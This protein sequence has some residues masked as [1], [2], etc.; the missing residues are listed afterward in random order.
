MTSIPETMRAVL[1]TGHGGID[2]LQYI[3][4]YPVPI[5]KDGEVLV[6]VGASSVNNT[7]IN[8]RTAWYADTVTGGVTV[9][10]GERGFDEVGGASSGWSGSAFTFP[11]I[12]GADICGEIVAVGE[13]V[14]Q[15]RIGARIL[16]DVWIRDPGSPLDRSKIGCIGSECDGGFA[17][18][19]AIP[20]ICAHT[21]QSD[22][23]D[24]ELA[25]FPCA[26]TTAENLV[27]RTRVGTGDTVLITGASGGVGSAAIQLCN[28]RGATVIGMAGTA[29]HTMLKPI[30]VDALLPREVDDLEASLISYVD[31]GQ[32]D[33]VIDTVGGNQFGMLIHQLRP[34]GRYA[35]CGAI[36]GPIVT[37]DVRDLI[38]QDLEFFGGTVPLPHVFEDLVG[39]IERNEITPIVAEVYDLQQLPAAQKEFLRKRVVGKII[40]SVSR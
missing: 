8:T 36:A 37:F 9:S 6:R 5:P 35:S 17:E 31:D 2:K 33:V 7:D 14:S 4:E 3:E 21:I 27:S 28:R 15:H 23:S 18:Y 39:Y 30:G 13:G 29:K 40:V 20:H 25:S 11:R 26:Y 12:Q 19:A 1:L 32:V 34:E 38:Y 22:L 10:A 24:A 16:A